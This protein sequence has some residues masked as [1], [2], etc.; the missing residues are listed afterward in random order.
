MDVF[1]GAD[2]NR[3]AGMH[4]RI[5]AG[6]FFAADD[7]R[8]PLPAYPIGFAPAGPDE[9]VGRSSACHNRDNIWHSALVLDETNP[10]SS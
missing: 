6:R 8:V 10:G 2:A 1:R 4:D 3:H 7:D 5:T 9:R